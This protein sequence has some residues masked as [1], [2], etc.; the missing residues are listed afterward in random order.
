MS[1]SELDKSERADRGIDELRDM[2]REMIEA[3]DKK[4]PGIDAVI[5]AALALEGLDRAEEALQ[6]WDRRDVYGE[7]REDPEPLTHDE[8]ARQARNL[9]E[10]CDDLEVTLEV[11]GEYDAADHVSVA[12]DVLE[13][14][15]ANGHVDWK[16]AIARVESVITA[17]DRGRD[18]I[19]THEKGHQMIESLRSDLCDLTSELKERP[20]DCGSPSQHGENQPSA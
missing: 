2:L 6:K 19:E 10:E 18:A 8:L 17:L 9:A 3:G 5:D 1:D 13:S 16:R 15:V 14:V 12:G 20:H 4:Y 7:W 11:D